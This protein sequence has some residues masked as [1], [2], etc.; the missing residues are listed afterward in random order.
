MSDA[1]RRRH[2]EALVWARKI[3]DPDFADWEAHV[4]WLEVDPHNSA[5]L[6]AALVLME[7]ASSDLGPASPLPAA[8]E[9]PMHVVNDNDHPLKDGT[10]RQRGRR[11]SLAV[12]GAIAAGIAAIAAVPAIMHRSPQPYRIE[13]ALGS[14][15]EIALPDGTFITLN[16]GSAVDLDHTNPRIATLVRGEAFFAVRHDPSHPFVAQAGGE[17]FQDVGTS[18]DMVRDTGSVRVAVREGAVMYD[19]KGAAV[20]VG[21]GHQIAVDPTGTTVETA[22]AGAIGGWRQGRLSYRYAPFEA[23]AADLS[24]SLGKPVRIDPEL[25]SRRFSGILIISDDHDLTV[26]RIASVMNVRV[27]HDPDGWHMT[28]L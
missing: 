19:P 21:G 12:G 6:D 28:A 9:V 27:L 17:L 23:I 14:T 3:Q 7:D 26:H 22:E 2:A 13:T 1:D 15:R 4:A 18:F 24:R 16:G 5:A 11:W 25:K 20:R 8:A 10:G